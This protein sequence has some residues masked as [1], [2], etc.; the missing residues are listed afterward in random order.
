MSVHI[1][2]VL[3]LIVCKVAI[4]GPPDQNAPMTGA[5]NLE[6]ATENS[7]MRCRR[8]ELQLY[9]PAEGLSLTAGGDPTS[10]VNPNLAEST[11][12]ARTGIDI[13]AQLGGYGV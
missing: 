11:Q 8:Q 6:W 12:C 5:Q 10:P 7:M 4:A 13:G 2:P 3:V 9:D 1:P